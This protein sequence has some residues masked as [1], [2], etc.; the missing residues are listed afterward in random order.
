MAINDLATKPIGKLLWHY[1]VP[2]V[3]G[4]LIWAFYNVVDRIY[5]GQGAGPEAI[6]GLAVTF[7]VM[8]LS[9][10]MGVLIG[11]GASSRTSILLGAKDLPRAE[12][13][14]GN[15]LVLTLVIGT[16]YTLCFGIWLDPILLA[17]GATEVTLPYAHDYMAYMLP[18]LMVTN[19][20]F[21]FNN[22]MRASGYPVKALI[23]N[24]LGALLNVVLDPIFIFGLDMGIRGAAIASVISM[25][26]GAA[27]VMW[28]FCKKSS[29][30]HFRRGI[31]RLDWRLIGD[32]MSLGIA[33]SV[34]NAA[35]SFITM[36]VNTSLVAYGS[37]IDVGACGIF[38]T[39]TSLLTSIVVGLNMGQ[40]PI[41]GYNYGAGNVHRLKGAYL[42]ATF[43]ATA[44]CT[45]GCAFGMLYPELI[46]R[47]FTTDQGL[48]DVTVNGLSCALWM[49]WAVGFP[50][51]S[52]GFFQSIGRA[53][54][55]I[56]LSLA[57]QI[58]FMYPLLHIL[59]I[60]W[61]LDGVW[62]SFPVSDILAV[63]VSAA[64]IWWQFQKIN[65]RIYDP[66]CN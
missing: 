20:C 38:I 4:M 24:M 63:I 10:A 53:P 36:K 5:I 47:C 57:R 2:S 46:A 42:L 31:Y 40:Q 48:I 11:V 41:I 52:T 59:P 66:V 50:I 55:S 61:E 9:A 28:H 32:I 21:S 30:V 39:Y 16:L 49:F 17:F 3:A 23:T 6:S 15:S 64:L 22:I 37:D 27:Y 19:L 56:V 44:I 54:E 58:I 26:I 25:F 51:T 35:S 45:L 60:W 33:P 62:L 12:Q 7:P 8:S 1:S 13:V 43:W 18:G 29:I 65:H 14:L 34:V